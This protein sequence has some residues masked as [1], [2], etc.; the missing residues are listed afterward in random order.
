MTR[1]HEAPTKVLEALESKFDLSY[2]AT[3]RQCQKRIPDGEGGEME[4]GKFTKGFAGRGNENRDFRRG[5][6]RCWEHRQK[7]KK[8]D[9]WKL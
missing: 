5:S 7:P 6:I 2:A 8:V 9:W 1:I 4:C 3:H